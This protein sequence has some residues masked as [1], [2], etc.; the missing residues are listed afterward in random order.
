MKHLGLWISVVLLT[1]AG[2]GLASYKV[3]VFGFPLRP[4]EEYQVWTIQA[5]FT[6]DSYTRPV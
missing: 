4:L 6:V 5:R 3:L 2:L 1:V